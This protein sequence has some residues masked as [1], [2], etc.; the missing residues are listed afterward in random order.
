[1]EKLTEYIELAQ[2]CMVQCKEE[3]PDSLLISDHES[4]HY[5]LLKQGYDLRGHYFFKVRIHLHISE[6][7]KIC[8]LENTTD[9]EIADFFLE[10]GV[11]KTDLLPAFLPENT[12]KLAGFAV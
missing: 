2:L 7:G 11:P 10:R 3:L 8:I 12:R 4:H 5:Q 6:A 9:I 1:M